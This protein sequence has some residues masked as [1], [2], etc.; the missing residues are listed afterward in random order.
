MH[1]E[2]MREYLTHS[3]L[4]EFHLVSFEP[5]FAFH[6]WLVGRPNIDASE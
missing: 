5:M 6:R 3:T 1:G 4:V 2:A